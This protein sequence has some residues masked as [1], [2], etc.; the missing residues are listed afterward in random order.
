[1][2]VMLFIAM[3]N[4]YRTAPFACSAIYKVPTCLRPGAYKPLWNLST[5]PY[6][7]RGLAVKW[8]DKFRSRWYRILTSITDCV[9]TDKVLFSSN[10]VFYFRVQW[11]YEIHSKVFQIIPETTSFG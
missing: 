2:A 7:R 9:K 4:S 3:E 10:P 8:V 1:M 11:L 6:Y 5:E